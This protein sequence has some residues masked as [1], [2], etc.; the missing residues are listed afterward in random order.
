[1]CSA[2]FLLTVDSSRHY[3]TP[4]KLFLGALLGLFLYVIPNRNLAGASLGNAAFSNNPFDPF[5]K[6]P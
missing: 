1:M 6:V 3:I 2:G 5:I 4:K